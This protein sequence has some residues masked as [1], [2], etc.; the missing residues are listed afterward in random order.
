[1][2]QISIR[3]DDEVYA[4]IQQEAEQESRS[5]SKQVN[6]IVKEYFKFKKQQKQETKE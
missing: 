5:F 3:F 6:Q 1:M 4:K 2:K